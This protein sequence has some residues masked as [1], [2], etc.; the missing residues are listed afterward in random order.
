MSSRNQVSARV[1]FLAAA[2][3][4]IAITATPAAARAQVA[5][6][7]AAD[8]ELVLSRIDPSSGAFT[9]LTDDARAGFF[10]AARCACPTSYGVTLA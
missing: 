7:G 4:A 6:L 10:S 9:A 8:F 1:A 5:A 3:G 2:A